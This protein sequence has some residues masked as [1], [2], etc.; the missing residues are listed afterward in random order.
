MKK[1]FFSL[2]IIGCASLMNVN[3]QSAVAVSSTDQVVA[4]EEVAVKKS[5]H[6]GE[7]KSTKACCSKDKAEAKA[8]CSDDKAT[9]SAGK[10]CCAS[11]AEASAV[12]PNSDATAKSKRK[13]K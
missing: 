7:A 10:A 9:A 6:D 11:K 5:C 13:Q 8:P 4:A 2:F 12:T 3:A 1:L